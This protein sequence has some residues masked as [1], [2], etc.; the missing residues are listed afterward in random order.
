[1]DAL[2]WCSLVRSFYSRSFSFENH[3]VG[4]SQATK[5]IQSNKK[6]AGI[7]GNRLLNRFNIT[8]DYSR[9]KIYFEKNERFEDDFRVNASGIYLQLSEN[10]QKI[11]AHKIYDNS[12]AKEAG[13]MQ[14]AQLV[15]VN[16]K[17]VSEYTLPELRALLLRSNTNVELVVMQEGEEKTVKLDLAQMI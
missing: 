13:I 7:I 9:E 17:N 14:N 3:P 5:G 2:L 12:P 1:M 16:G 11:L 10:Q 8:F 15:S 4:I 6:M